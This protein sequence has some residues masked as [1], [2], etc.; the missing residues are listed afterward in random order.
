MRVKLT[1]KSVKAR[2][3]ASKTRRVYKENTEEPNFST[4]ACFCVKP[5]P[6]QKLK[7]KEAE[8]AAKRHLFQD[9]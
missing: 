3:L 2:V 7:P 9:G 6:C 1:R 4:N 5:E 8:Y